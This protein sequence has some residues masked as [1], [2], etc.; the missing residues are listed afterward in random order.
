MGKLKNLYSSA[1]TL[2]KEVFEKFPFTMVVVYAVTALFVFG[3]E[4]FIDMLYDSGWLV[5]IALSAMGIF[6]VENWFKEELYLGFVTTILIAIGFRY[7]FNMN[8]GDSVEEWLNKIFITYTW[9][10]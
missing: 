7:W 1:A 2:V 4:E 10:K 8:L 6:A 3:T 5:V 9:Y